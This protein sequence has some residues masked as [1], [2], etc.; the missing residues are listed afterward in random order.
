[1]KGLLLVIIVFSIS[2]SLFGEGFSESSSLGTRNRYRANRGIIVP[3]EEIDGDSYIAA[4]D[5][6]YPEPE[7]DM[8]GISLYNRLTQVSSQGQEGIL[9]IGLQ[10]KSQPFPELPP[11][12]LVL[13]IDTSRSM[14]EDDKIAWVKESMGSFMNKIREIDSL[15]LVGFNDTAQVIFES[16]RM[17]SPQKRQQF[18]EAVNT[19]SPAGG[20]T[21]EPGLTLGYEQALINYQEGAMNL[22]LLCSDGTELSARLAKALAHSGDIQISLIWYNRHDMDL[23]VIPPGGEEINYGHKTDSTGG[24]LDVDRNVAGE[25]T[26]PVENVFW[27]HPPQGQYRVYVQNYG[28]NESDHSPITFQVELKNGNEYRY[29]EGTV[30]GTGEDSNTEV[31][32]FEFQG[33]ATSA[34]IYQPLEAYRQQRIALSTLGVGG[35]FNEEFLRFL[36]E[37]GQGNSRSLSSREMLQHIFDTDKEFERIAVPAARDL[38]MELEFMPGIEILEAWGYPHRIENN[39]IF[40][41]LPVLYQGDYK[42]LLV[43]YRIPPQNQGNEP[44]RATFRVKNTQARS[45]GSPSEKTATI[46]LADSGDT[47]AS[48]MVRYAE[49]MVHFSEALKDIGGLYYAKGDELPQRQAALQKTREISQELENAKQRLQ[50]PEA[51]IHELAILARYDALLSARLPPDTGGPPTEAVSRMSGERGTTSRMSSEGGTV[52]RMSSG[53]GIGSP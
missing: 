42:T 30:S 46:L 19:L 51:F 4:F 35:N 6:H 12:N 32:T 18:L 10:G 21:L 43:H 26:Q 15:G 3:P 28:Y 45:S 7:T 23:H 16:T 41:R 44:P 24:W 17:D 25:T 20:T 33:A 37:Q 47:E 27:Y 9:Q 5:Y 1:M 40:Y 8:V 14:E 53:T 34:L 22:V 38:E 13:V 52:S 29:F 48:R 50:A 31:C 11:L 49:T 39:R 36:A 2:C